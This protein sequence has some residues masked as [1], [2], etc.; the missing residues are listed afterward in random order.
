MMSNDELG[1]STAASLN[2][3]VLVGLVRPYARR[4]ILGRRCGNLDM[5]R[6]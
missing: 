5:T 6:G 2:P 3:I 4:F 1:R